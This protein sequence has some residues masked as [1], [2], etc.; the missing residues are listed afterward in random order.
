MNIA[1]TT[2]F[3]SP[4]LTSYILFIV[5][6]EKILYLH[7]FCRKSANDLPKNVQ[8]IK[9]CRSTIREAFHT[10]NRKHLFRI[11]ISQS[12]R[13]PNTGKSTG[14]NLL[15]HHTLDAVW[16]FEIFHRRLKAPPRCKYGAVFLAFP[17]DISRLDILIIQSGFSA[18]H[19]GSF[20]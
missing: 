18:D 15:F 2:A 17:T 9:I 6:R 4:P 19:K 1:I 11:Q 10:K 16:E 13:L 5:N 12:T 8:A 14:R 7:I 3:P 20:L